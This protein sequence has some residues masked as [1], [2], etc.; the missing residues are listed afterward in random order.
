MEAEREAQEPGARRKARR[1]TAAAIF[2]APA[3]VAGVVAA[4]YLGAFLMG[5]CFFPQI[6]LC[7]ILFAIGLLKRDGFARRAPSAPFWT[8]I[9]MLWGQ[10]VIF[11]VVCLFMPGDRNCFQDCEGVPVGPST[12]EYVLRVRAGSP[13]IGRLTLPDAACEALFQAGCALFVAAPVVWVGWL[14]RD[15]VRRR[16]ARKPRPDVV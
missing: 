2:L 16:G 10:L 13:S 8:A 1:A 6:W 3:P 12:A 9:G 11:W 7:W 14:A 5:A 15:H 4:G